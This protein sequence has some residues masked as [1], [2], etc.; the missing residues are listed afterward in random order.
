M[1]GRGA[2]GGA[3][4]IGLDVADPPRAADPAEAGNPFNGSLR[5]R[6]KLFEGTVV[7][8]RARV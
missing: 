4:N 6:G 1:A 7:S 2:K 8:A 5:I 3:A